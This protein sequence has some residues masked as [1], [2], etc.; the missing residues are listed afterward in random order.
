MSFKIKKK[1]REIATYFN[2]FFFHSQPLKSSLW[3]FV[4]G[5]VEMKL[6]EIEKGTWYPAV[7]SYSGSR[8][9]AEIEIVENE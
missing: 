3:P 6:I 9:N 5:S 7:K 8:G 2:S 4:I 1:G